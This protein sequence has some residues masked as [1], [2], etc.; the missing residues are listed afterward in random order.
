VNREPSNDRY[1][2]VVVGSGLGG[3]SAAALLAQT[4]R[5]VLV[6]ERQD[7]PGGYAHAFQR[8]PYLF[9][10]AIHF[11]VEAG[12]G[13]MLDLL[14]RDLG[15]REQCDLTLVDCFYRTVFPGG[16]NLRVPFGH[17]AVVEAYAAQFPGDADGI[18]KF[19]EL[20]RQFF[21]DATHMAMQLSFSG[22]DGAM[23]RFPTF[24]RY[25]NATV[26]DAL[27]EYVVDARAK[28]A[29]SSMWPYVGVP[30]SMASYYVFAQFMSV[31]I[32]GGSYYCRGSFQRLADAFVSATVKRGGELRLNSGVTRIMVE[33]GRVQ[34]VR[35][36]SG[37]EL[38]APVVIS[39]ADVRQTLEQLVGEEQVPAPLLRRTRRMRPSLSAFVI[40][41]ATDLDLTQHDAAHETFLYRHWD[42]D[43]TYVDVQEGQPGGMW[44]SV[45][46]LADPSL[47]PP[48]QHLVV[49]TSLAPYHTD[50]S[51][52]ADRERFADETLAAVE[53]AYPGLRRH[54]T[55][56]ETATP[57]TLR[58]NTLNTDGAIYGW[59]LTPD[60][61]GSKRSPHETPID[62]LYL[63]GHWTHEGAGSFRTIL[64][65]VMTA[66]AVAEKA[67][68][69]EAISAFRPADLPSIEGG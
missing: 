28:A 50:D 47:A 14:L 39:N 6:V 54:L 36:E 62:G 37:Q 13:R 52:E 58:E 57:H 1:D 17:E 25:R 40:Y 42:H 63:S 23:E 12:E 4:G 65:G 8:G 22:L 56:M 60:Q 10:P 21:F 46:T 64:S 7:G 2:V 31:L 30:P 16:F 69:R 51:W 15:V 24:F 35:L 34:G 18:R 32:D 68:E 59:A 61:A 29:L 20:R 11:T 55:Y 41:A 45:P 26:Q 44:V 27:D 19:F 33:G 3:L 49:I 43:R 9:D 67:G 5:R 66:R 53:D 48:G 38:H